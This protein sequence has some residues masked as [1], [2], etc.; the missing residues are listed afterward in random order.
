MK[1]A[2][3]ILKARPFDRFG[4]S[5]FCQYWLDSEGFLNMHLRGCREE[6]RAVLT[7]Q[8]FVSNDFYFL[9]RSN[10]EDSKSEI[11]TLAEE[12]KKIKKILSI[13]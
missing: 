9:N 12:I 1:L 4:T 11:E 10:E 6:G 2:E 3:I 8:D 7:Y 13:R 5:E